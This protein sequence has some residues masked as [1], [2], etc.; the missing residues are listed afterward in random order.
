MVAFEPPRNIA[1]LSFSAL[2][3]ES[4]VESDVYTGHVSH[5]KFER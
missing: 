5:I 1:C 3:V 4:R 2:Q